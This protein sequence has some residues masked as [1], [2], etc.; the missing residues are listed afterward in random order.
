MNKKTKSFDCVE[1][2]RQGAARVQA[3]IAGMTPEE[4]LEFWRKQTEE[5]R[6]QQEQIRRTRTQQKAT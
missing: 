4:E 2:K 6:K 3:L 1:M 5:L